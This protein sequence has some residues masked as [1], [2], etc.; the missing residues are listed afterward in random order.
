M[1][2]LPSL[3]DWKPTR[4]ALH[5][6]SRILGEIR[7]LLSK[8]HPLWWHVSLQVVSEGLSTGPLALGS[9]SAEISLNL[10]SHEA[11]I[12]AANSQEERIPLG[13]DLSG[14]ELAEYCIA[15]LKPGG[16]IEG[17]AGADFDDP[18]PR[19]S[20]P[21]AA[22]RFHTALR[23]VQTAFVEAQARICGDCSPIQIWPHHFD[24]SFEWLATHA[25]TSDTDA[26][27][28]EGRCQ[29]GFGFSPGDNGHEEPYFYANPWPFDL[30]LTELPLPGSAR[31][32]VEGWKGSLLTYAEVQS[33]GE[34][35]LLDYLTAVYSAAAPRFGD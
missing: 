12:H 1:S 20:D 10:E 34:N 6:Y 5:T 31:W 22:R 7:R 15:A 9:G 35:L 32:H 30:T 24:L 33:A 28:E 25:P 4:E 11:V 14:A 26:S 21:E 19:Q 2:N 16:E 8:P 3:S 18:S 17:L 29:I 13:A 23:G 27:S